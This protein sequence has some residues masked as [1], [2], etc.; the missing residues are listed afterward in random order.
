MDI[1]LVMK[2][3]ENIAYFTL[4]FIISFMTGVSMM[5]SS[6]FYTNPI[7]AGFYPDPSIC[8]VGEDF[9]LINSTFAYFPSIP[10]FHSKDLVSWELIGHVIDRKE[11]LNLVGFGVS[12]G[13]FAPAIRYHKGIFYVTCTVVDG[14]GNFVVTTTNPA[15]PWSNP[16]WL[17]EISGIDPS[18]FFDDDDK[19]YIVYNSEPPDN[20]PLYDG[21]RTIKIVEFDYKN[22]KVS[23]KPKIIVNGGVDISKKPIWIEGPHIFKLSNWYYLIC[24]EG[25][26]AEDHSQV[27]FRSKNVFGPYEAYKKAPILTQRHLN[28][29]R[30]FPITCTGHSDFVELPDGSWWAVFLGCRPYEPF[31]ENYYNTGRETFLAPIRWKDGWPIITEGNEE[32]KYF[33]PLPL[34]KR[35]PVD[36][37]PYSGNFKIRDDF[38]SEKLHPT[39]IFLRTPLEQWYSIDKINGGIVIKLRPE[40]CAQYGNPSFIGRRLAHSKGYATTELLFDPEAENEKAGVLIFQDE[41]H[42]YYLC[43]SL[44]NNKLVVE[45]YQ[46]DEDNP[47]EY[48]KLISFRELTQKK[49]LFL[50]IVFEGKYFNFYFGYEEN[51][52]ELLNDKIDATFLS[53]RMA[54]GFTG[55]VIALY[56][57]SLG[58]ESKNTA[59]YKFFEYCGDD[60]V[61]KQKQ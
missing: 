13:I 18:L 36:D 35:I 9:Y 39:W 30:K 22:L 28:P 51:K 59:T 17:P 48:M 24:A 41:G 52:M 8:R 4:F 27:V 49:P 12:R 20:K 47:P 57:T 56:A 29:A 43:K 33:Y 32:V 44:K 15:G 11:Q 3:K 60:D 25:G 45:L 14:N 10:V 37:L 19:A 16:V 34:R 54:W 26:T 40:N 58:K 21:H 61:Y 42:F 50:K 7:L 1:K 53:I 5:I 31:Y 55:N 38:K 23:G 6:D 2:I 46:S